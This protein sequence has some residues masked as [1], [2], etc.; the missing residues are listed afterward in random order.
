ML[1]F[2][3]PAIKSRL[4]YKIQ[5][6]AHPKTASKPDVKRYINADIALISWAFRLTLNKVWGRKQNSVNQPSV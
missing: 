4:W 6:K 2:F 1:T 3:V 5:Q